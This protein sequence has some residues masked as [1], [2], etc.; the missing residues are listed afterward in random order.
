MLYGKPSAIP[1]LDLGDSH[2]CY[3]IVFSFLFVKY[4]TFNGGKRKHTV[5]AIQ[6]N[7]YFLREIIR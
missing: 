4:E 6:T 1:I 5:V 2:N 7:I 3:C